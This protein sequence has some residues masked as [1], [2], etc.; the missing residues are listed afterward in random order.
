[1]RRL[2]HYA[3][4]LL[5]IIPWLAHAAPTLEIQ[6]TQGVFRVRIETSLAVDVM[7]AWLVLTDYDHLADFVPDM[8]ASRVLNAPRRPRLV[9][10]RGEAA[11]MLFRTNIEVLLEVDE[12]PPLRLGFRAIGGDMKQMQGEWRISGTGHGVV[13]EYEAT[14]EPDFWVPPL[15]G[16]MLMRRNMRRQFAGVTGEMLRRYA[17]AHDLAVPG[18]DSDGFIR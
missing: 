15:L 12:T 4:A 2:P 9:Q 7:T 16:D 6:R 5:V 13:L 10:Q 8:Q 11:F 3:G 1:M 18:F 17:E 14:L